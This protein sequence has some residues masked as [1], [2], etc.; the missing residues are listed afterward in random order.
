MLSMPRLLSKFRWLGKGFTLIELLVVIAIIAILI[1]LLLPAVQ[2]VREAAARMSCQNNLKQFGLANHSYHDVNRFFPPGGQIGTNG[3]WGDERGSWLVYILPYVEQDNMY[4]IIQWNTYAP[5]GSSA[6]GAMSNANFVNGRVIKNYRCPSDG[7]FIGQPYSNYVGSMGP[8]C[9]PS[10]CSFAPY[11][12][13]CQPITA[14][15]GNWGYDTSADHGNTTDSS[16]LRGMFNRLGC[17]INIA[18]V[19]DGT[20]NT[21]MLG[22]SLPTQHDHLTNGGWQGLNG[23]AAHVTTIVPINYRSDGSSCGATP[24]GRDAWNVSWGFK[25]N[26]SGGANFVFAD[27]S[28]RFLPQSIDHMTFQLLGCRND[29][30]PVTLP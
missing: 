21:I 20:S 14:G 2:K 12:K 23:G 25:S 18:S 5:L 15:L 6:T 27:G 7:S 4:K 28:V 30:L 9:A 8:Q 3:D 22:E 24:P 11:Y 16:Q 29:G 17:K 26:H 1:G 13:Y 10:N 19:T